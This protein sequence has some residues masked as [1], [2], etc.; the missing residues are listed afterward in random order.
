MLKFEC[1]NRENTMKNRLIHPKV[2]KILHQITEP[3]PVRVVKDLLQP[4]SGCLAN[5]QIPTLI[6]SNSSGP[7][8]KIKQQITLNLNMNRTRVKRLSITNV[9]EINNT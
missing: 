8:E 2:L 9:N 7:I 5:K 4:I 3:S 6:P 1:P